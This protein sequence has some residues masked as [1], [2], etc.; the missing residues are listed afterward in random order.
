MRTRA[1]LILAMTLVGVM[2]LTNYLKTL[3]IGYHRV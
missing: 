2:V 1:L 3:L